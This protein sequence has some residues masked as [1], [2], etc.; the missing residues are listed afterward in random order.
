MDRGRH[1]GEESS[2]K[3]TNQKRKQNISKSRYG[4]YKNLFAAFPG[5][6]E[7]GEKRRTCWGLGRQKKK[8]RI[9]RGPRILTFRKEPYIIFKN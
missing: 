3:T 1:V 9:S 2:A 4:Y 7:E 8:L 6:E 5:T